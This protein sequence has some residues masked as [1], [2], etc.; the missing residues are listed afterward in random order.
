MICPSISKSLF[1]TKVSYLTGRV[2]TVAALKERN[3]LIAC[4]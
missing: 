2:D 4:S 3:M 1:L